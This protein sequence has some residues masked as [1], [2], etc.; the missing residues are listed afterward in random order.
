LNTPDENQD[1]RQTQI[2][3]REEE[4]PYA[5]EGDDF[6]D[7]EDNGIVDDKEVIADVKLARTVRA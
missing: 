7:A 1:A 4:N 2:P 3:A 6:N 5:I